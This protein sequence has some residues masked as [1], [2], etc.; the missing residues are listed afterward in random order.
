MQI[1]SLDEKQLRLLR[2]SKIKYPKHFKK[3]LISAYGD[4]H[5]LY[6][7]INGKAIQLGEFIDENFKQSWRSGEFMK[8]WIDHIRL[9]VPGFTEIE[10]LL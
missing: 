6:R 5:K 2:K 3:D 1:L 10:E 4:S 7:A 8:R 9:F